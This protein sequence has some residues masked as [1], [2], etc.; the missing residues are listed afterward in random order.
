MK[1]SICIPTYNR[2]TLLAE[3]LDALLAEVS[4]NDQ[5][6]ILISDNASTDATPTLARDYQARYPQIRY[7]RNVENVGFDGN[8]V[9][10]IEQARGEYVA[11]FSDDDLPSP[12]VFVAALNALVNHKPAILYLNHYP[13]Y[14]EN[15]RA[16]IGLKHPACDQLF[17]DGKQFLLAAGLGFISALTVRAD[18]AR[19]F[20]P[21]VKRGRGQAHLDI[22]VRIALLKPGPFALLGTQA[23][24][25]RAQVAYDS[26]T[27]AAIN[28]ASFYHE[29][30][31]EGLLD[32]AAVRRRVGGSIS[33]NLLRAVL[34]KKCSA[35]HMQL[36]EQM[37]LLVKTYRRYPQFYLFVYPILLLPRVFLIGPYQLGRALVRWRHARHQTGGGV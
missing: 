33:H 20:I 27:Y 22:A 4:G 30:E 16:R 23:V 11:F 28:E 15:Y 7:H 10:C 12:G 2:A 1:L 14:G 35:N 32:P 5:V 21:N 37:P 6:E 18:Y 17:A 25:A 34:A 19:E 3:A 9:V 8:V 13:F 29:L 36:K 26:V 31:A 24:A